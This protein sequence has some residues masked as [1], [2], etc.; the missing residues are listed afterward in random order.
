VTLF[1]PLEEA[2]FEEHRRV[3]E[4][5]LYG[6]IFAARALVPVFRRQRHGVL[7]NVGSI[8]SKVG[9]PFVPSYAISKFGLRG[10]SESLRME[11]ADEPDVH[12]CLLL[13]YAI[14]TPHF[15][16]GANRVGRQAHAMAPV[17]TPE[18]VA[19]ALVALAEHPQRERHVPRAASLLLP[20]RDL[21]PRTAERLILHALQQWHFDDEAEPST[22]GNLYGP[23]ARS[24]DVRGERPPLIGAPRLFAWAARELLT[25]PATSALQHARTTATRWL[26][27]GAS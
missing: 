22:S 15:E 23:E 25:M 7:I 6:P 2:S 4:T 12:V 13:P 3:I 19:Q 11:L 16:S 5:N 24:G 18:E 14:D 1:A 8:L 26:Y 21:L 17:Q 20:L 10:M 27:G 9:Q